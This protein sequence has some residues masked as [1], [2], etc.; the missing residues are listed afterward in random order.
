[1]KTKIDGLMSALNHTDLVTVKFL[2][3]TNR[4]REMECTRLLSSIPE[5]QRA[6]ISTPKLN[7]PDIVCVYDWL[8]HEWRAFRIDSVISYNGIDFVVNS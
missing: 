6:G 4:I 1:M 5:N 2:T 7:G 3:K 8:V